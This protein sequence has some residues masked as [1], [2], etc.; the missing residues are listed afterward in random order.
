MDLI[1]KLLCSLYYVFVVDYLANQPVNKCILPIQ[2]LLFSMQEITKIFLGV[3]VLRLLRD[4]VK[5]HG[6][7]L[8]S[9]AFVHVYSSH[10]VA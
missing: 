7:E 10:V 2:F 1:K 9:G 5:R 8:S 6:P 4:I 3:F